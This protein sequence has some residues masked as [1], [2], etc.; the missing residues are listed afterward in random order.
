M[1]SE[2]YGP[3]VVDVAGSLMLLATTGGGTS[4]HLVAPESTP[5]S[6]RGAVEDFH[7]DADQSAALYDRGALAERKWSSATL[8]GRAWAVMVG[9]EGGPIGVHGET[10]FAPTC[11]RCLSLIDRFSPQP[12]LDPRHSLVVDLVVRTVLDKGFAEVH[13]VPGDQQTELR[14]QVRHS[15]RRRSGHSVKTHSIRGIIYIECDPI[16]RQHAREYDGQVTDAISAAFSGDP[17][18]R[19][20]R[21]W[22][23]SWDTWSVD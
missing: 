19:I 21:D 13:G 6:G 14:R 4:V 7:F 9:G 10:A 12:T 18:P 8:C 22:V 16:Y 17:V 3:N 20:E 1:V 23:V 2:R 5:E 15:I 11:R